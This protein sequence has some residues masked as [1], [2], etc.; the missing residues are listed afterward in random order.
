MPW[1]GGVTDGPANAVH[2]RSPS[3]R[4][5]D[6]RAVRVVRRV[7]EDGVQMDRPVS[8]PWAGRLGRA[9][10]PAAAVAESDVRGDR[11]RHP[12]CPASSPE[13]GRQETSGAAG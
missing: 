13:L 6:Y 7:P 12:R 10:A 1:K 2:R 11:S 9:I 3:L 4:A 5:L 8:A